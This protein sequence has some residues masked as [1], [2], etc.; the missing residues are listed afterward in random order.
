ML[1]K[2]KGKKFVLLTYCN[3]SLVDQARRIL[4]DKSVTQN[5]LCDKLIFDNKEDNYV[6]VKNQI[7][8]SNKTK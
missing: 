1:F 3:E 7:Y 2:I 5:N 4:K 8:K 6:I